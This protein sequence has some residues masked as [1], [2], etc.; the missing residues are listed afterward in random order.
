MA[1]T[2]KA[3]SFTGLISNPQNSG[4]DATNLLVTAT[5]D[6]TTI[7]TIAAN[8]REYAKAAL[9]GIRQNPSFRTL[10]PTGASNLVFAVATAY[11]ALAGNPADPSGDAFI[12]VL[13]GVC[14]SQA[15]TTGKNPSALAQL[16]YN[17]AIDYLT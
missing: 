4:E 14:S 8:L 10:D 17:L 5:A 12:Q 1:T 3:K 16:A 2:Y 7:G 15:S 9:C 6:E 13:E 11:Q